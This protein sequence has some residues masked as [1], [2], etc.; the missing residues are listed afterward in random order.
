MPRLC[1]G[2][3]SQSQAF[4]FGVGNCVSRLAVMIAALALAFSVSPAF[5]ASDDE[6]DTGIV[7]DD[8]SDTSGGH[9]RFEGRA[10]PVD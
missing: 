1:G 9:R 6:P 10:Q 8:S 3:G 5:A 2:S 4:K 7:D